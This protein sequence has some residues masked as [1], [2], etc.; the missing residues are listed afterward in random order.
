V[1]LK[2]PATQLRQEFE[3]ETSLP[4]TRRLTAR[5]RAVME[6]ENVEWSGVVELQELDVVL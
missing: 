1:P 5:A 6:A 2:V 4:A 3:S